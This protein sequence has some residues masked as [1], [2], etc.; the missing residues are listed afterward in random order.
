M[1]KTT[2]LWIILDLIFIIIFNA[3]FFVLGGTEHNVSV[4]I[5]YG[6]IHFAY[7]MLLLTPAL[8]SKGKSAVV[9]GFSLFS[10]SAVYFFT[11]FVTG[12]IFIAVSPESYIAALSVQLCIAGLYGIM[13]VANMLANEHTAEVEEK[14]QNQID[15]VKK[16][17]AELKGLLESITDKDM[18]KKV[19]RV[20]DTLYSS[21]VKSHPNLA[22]TESQILLSIGDLANAVSSGNKDMIISLADSLLIA[23]DERNSQLKMLN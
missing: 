1:K 18:K 22:Q 4:W 6:F 7:F 9:F 11:E 8:I 16:A 15:Y 12:I 23:V 3:I 17:S 19:E 10:I 2:V 14:R 13:L 21:P 5:S 20:Y